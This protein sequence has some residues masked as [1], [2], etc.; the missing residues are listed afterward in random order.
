[1]VEQSGLNPSLMLALVKVRDTVAGKYNPCITT[2]IRAVLCPCSFIIAHPVHDSQELAL[3]FLVV[4][5][6]LKPPNSWTNKSTILINAIF[7]ERLERISL[8]LV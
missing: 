7:Q 3:C 5:P 8:H 4:H 1:M 2:T 6:S